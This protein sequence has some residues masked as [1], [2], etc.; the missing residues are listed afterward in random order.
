MSAL[1]RWKKRLRAVFRQDAVDREMD[2]E[3]AFHLEL[4]IR[5]NEGLGMSPAEARRQAALTFGGVERYKEQ[6]RD[7]RVLS[8][9]GGM[10]LDFKLGLRML[11]RYPG[12]TI[13]GGLAIAFAVCIGAGTFEF[14][15]QVFH[16]KLPLPE[17]A[18]ALTVAAAIGLSSI[19]LEGGEAPS[20]IAAAEEMALR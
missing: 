18:A 2:E 8:W 5:K 1:K 7:A 15:S 20:Q 6:V 12:L 17:I 19:F 9:V 16:P 10:S 4:E 14:M 13:V 11:G 3:L